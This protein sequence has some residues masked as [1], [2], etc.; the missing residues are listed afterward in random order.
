MLEWLEVRL[1]V[2]D[3]KRFMYK[4]RIEALNSDGDVLK[5]LECCLARIAGSGIQPPTHHQLIKHHRLL[6]LLATN[7]TAKYQ[8]PKCQLATRAQSTDLSHSRQIKPGPRLLSLRVRPALLSVVDG[9]ECREF[10]CTAPTVSSGCPR[11]P[12]VLDK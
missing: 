2:G 7:S 1:D 3:D 8:I 11:R 4:C 9:H 6:Q 12:Q 5:Q 10:D